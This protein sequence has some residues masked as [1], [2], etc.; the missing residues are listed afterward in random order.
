MDPRASSHVLGMKTRSLQF[1]A[2]LPLLGLAFSCGGGGAT[3]QPSAAPTQL[4]R[5]STREIGNVVADLVGESLLTDRFVEETY[6][7]GYD[8]GPLDLT[9]QTDEASA[10]DL[11]ASDVAKR[12]VAKHAD[13]LVGACVYERDGQASCAKVFVEGFAAR[14][15]RRPL[16]P[17]EARRLTDLLDAA[18]KVGGFTLGLEVAT[19]A[20][21]ESGPL[22]YRE[23]SGV[24]VGSRRQLTPV[25]AASALSFFVTGTMPDAA[26]TAAAN[27]GH[28]VSGED[29]H[30]E[31]ARLL[32]APAARAD[33][34]QFFLEW[35]GL[36]GLSSVG[37]D[38]VTYPEYDAAL[39]A[40]MQAELDGYVDFA[41]WEGDGSLAQLFSSNVSFVDTR[42]AAFY[43]ISGAG[44]S[45]G[46]AGPQ[47]VELDRASR[48]GLLTRAGFL[49]TH[50]GYDSSG[51]IARG[52]FVRSALLC[53]PPPPP[54]PNIPRAVSNASGHTTRERFADHTRSSFCQG[55]HKGI[56][57]VGFGFEQFDGIGRLRQMEG[58][59]V[60]DTSGWLTD[61]G[62][63]G[64][65]VGVSALEDLLLA[66][67]KMAP[68][69]V[70]QLFRFAMGRAE[71]PADQPTLDALLRQF[72]AHK[73]I[74][75]LVLE[76]ASTDA[77]VDRGSL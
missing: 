23:E 6:G 55:C 1:L 76:L 21:L 68:C 74:T 17:A 15:Y 45:V 46:Y 59:E 37:K 66:S 71:T 43:G 33:L 20:V 25:E 7:T 22:L 13:K 44:S 63:D 42:L 57:G 24:A 50:A 60:V 58:G 64:P 73:R 77:F 2:T 69:F 56:D 62:A 52:V 54:P 19:T 29:R 27:E 47:R 31:A 12:A 41:V 9:M 16:H 72:D 53:A 28:L 3:V 38:R 18:S 36:T 75:D 35:L 67:P 61:S 70:T 30:R 26:L 34:R 40:S 5:L 14:A 11:A 48:R 4:R 10:L 51:P 8:N 39:G 49:T 32:K 65:F